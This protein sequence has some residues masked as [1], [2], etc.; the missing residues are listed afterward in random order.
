VG[1]D[2]L[3]VPHEA[4]R[5]AP[6]SDEAARMAAP[7]AATLIGR[8]VAYDQT[9]RARPHCSGSFLLRVRERDAWRLEAID[10]TD[11][12]WCTSRPVGA[13]L[14]V[15]RL[16]VDGRP[17]TLLESRG[18]VREGGRLTIRARVA[19]PTLLR[20]VDASTG[21]DVDR[22]ELALGVASAA[23][24]TYPAPRTLARELVSP[25]DL[26]S[27][28]EAQLGAPHPTVY[29][30]RAPGY[31]WTSILVDHA[32]GGERLLALEHGRRLSVTVRGGNPTEG[33]LL[34][35]W[36]AA[37]G[38]R[39][40]LLLEQPLAVGGT[41]ELNGIAAGSYELSLEDSA[42]T[43]R[44][45]SLA[46]VAMPDRDRSIELKVD[47]V[48]AEPTR[49]FGQLHL[50][51]AWAALDP[52]LEVRREHGP[53][54][55]ASLPASAMAR[56]GGGPLRWSAGLLPPGRYELR[57]AACG[58]LETIDLAAVAERGHEAR[59][60]DPARVSVRTLTAGRASLSE[61]VRLSWSH[62]DLEGSG[63]PAEVDS[64][65]PSHH[66][67][68]APAGRLLVRAVDSTGRVLADE[69][70]IVRSGANHL[71]L[72]LRGSGEILVRLLDGVRPVPWNELSHRVEVRSLATG[73]PVEI[74]PPAGSVPGPG[75]YE[76]RFGVFPGYEPVPT[77]R[78][79]VAESQTARVDVLLVRSF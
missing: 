74:D 67:F 1:S 75:E 69:E 55:L 49:L 8:L 24:E 11:G 10:V 44:V 47:E 46:T 9:G 53:R 45:L 6:T 63:G 41:T 15:L 65:D 40:T 28:T 68:H 59:I 26:D 57:I 12:R 70:R 58:F 50:S 34:R 51:S 27:L 43:P 7:A 39:R 71:D 77:R 37:A 22:I 52:V 29:W 33:S 16:S 18:L 76:L 35:L 14:D 3:H 19:P 56:D 31:A 60:A 17:A 72:S 30:V 36:I 4:A 38:D 73:E 66:S 23:R 5:R 13:S 54:V 62:A 48:G 21:R 64:T 61:G 25:I 2:S 42:R 79:W 78:V 32:E 20:V